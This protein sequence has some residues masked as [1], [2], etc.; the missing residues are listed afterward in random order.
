MQEGSKAD[1]PVVSV[2]KQQSEG[3]WDSHHPKQHPT[4]ATTNWPNKL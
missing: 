1:I 2:D 4:L 3:V